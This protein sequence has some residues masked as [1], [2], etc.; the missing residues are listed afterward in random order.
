MVV[1]PAVPAGEITSSGRAVFHAIDQPGR[2]TATLEAAAPSPVRP[3]PKGL[4]TKAVEPP[5]PKPMKGFCDPNPRK[6]RSPW[7]KEKERLQI[8]RSF[9]TDYA[10]PLPICPWSLLS[11]PFVT[12]DIHLHILSD[13]RMAGQA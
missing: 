5:Q 2:R 1:P 3:T 10:K 12:L 9:R 13:C 11:F 7:H 8:L 6:S 4:D